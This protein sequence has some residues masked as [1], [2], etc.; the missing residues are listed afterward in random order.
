M[1][2]DLRERVQCV[3]LVEVRDDKKPMENF[4]ELLQTIPQAQFCL[5]LY[6]MV[7]DIRVSG[8]CVLGKALIQPAKV[9]ELQH[10]FCPIRVR[11]PFVCQDTT[12]QSARFHQAR[13]EFIH[14]K[15]GGASR[16]RSMKESVRARD[17]VVESVDDPDEVYVRLSE[18]RRDFGD[19][20]VTGQPVKRRTEA[21]HQT[22][23]TSMWQ[24]IT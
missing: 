21:T 6:L 20:T 18:Y 10:T 1:V 14:L 5:R 2:C 19:P 16:V 4:K 9:R 7:L 12:S 13:T 17:T 24:I 23:H 15:K 22:H 8:I 3:V 11:L